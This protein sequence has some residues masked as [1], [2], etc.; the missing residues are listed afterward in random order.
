MVSEWKDKAAFPAGIVFA[1]L[2]STKALVWQPIPGLL[3]TVANLGIDADL[4]DGEG[5]VADNGG[6]ETTT[7][8]SVQI[9]KFMQTFAFQTAIR[10]FDAVAEPSDP[11]ILKFAS[12]LPWIPPR[13]IFLQ[14]KASVDKQDPQTAVISTLL[15]D[16]KRKELLEAEDDEF[17]FEECWK[18]SEAFFTKYKG[19]F[20]PEMEYVGPYAN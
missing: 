5:W 11:E 13:F 10:K 14:L 20:T 1:Y 2:E 16:T 7:P 4:S 9:T 15:L 18:T 17:F 19:M 8:Y 3:T 6:I 12:H